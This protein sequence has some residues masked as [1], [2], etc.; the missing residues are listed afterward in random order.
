[1]KT[2]RRFRTVRAEYEREIRYMLAHSQR[3]EGS[4]AAKSSAKWATS[5]K[6]QMARALSTHVG[7]CPECG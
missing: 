1:M 4:P 3:Y 5:T 6:Q 7:S 2:C